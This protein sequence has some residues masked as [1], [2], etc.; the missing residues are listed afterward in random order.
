MNKKLS[1]H[2]FSGP[3]LSIVGWQRSVGAYGQFKMMNSPNKHAFELWAE[4]G[5]WRK[6]TRAQG[7]HANSEFGS[8]LA[9]RQQ[10]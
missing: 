6:R 7:E 2:P 9:V 3:A 8:L 5:A 10:C 1:I 4:A